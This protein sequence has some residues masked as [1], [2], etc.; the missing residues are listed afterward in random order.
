LLKLEKNRIFDGFNLEIRDP[1]ILEISIFEIP[2]LKKSEILQNL[3]IIQSAPVFKFGAQKT[4]SWPCTAVQPAI[5]EKYILAQNAP[6]VLLGLL[7]SN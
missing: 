2:G 1:G 5:Y 4:H 6:F 3:I 7:L